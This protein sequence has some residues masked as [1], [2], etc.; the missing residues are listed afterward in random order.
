MD[1]RARGVEAEGQRHEDAVHAPH[2]CSE[3]RRR[4]QEIPLEDLDLSLD[5]MPVLNGPGDEVRRAAPQE[6]RTHESGPAEHQCGGQ[7]HLALVMAHHGDSPAPASPER[8]L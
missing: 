5:G 2:P 4:L 6:G 1:R 3:R 7:H 8:C